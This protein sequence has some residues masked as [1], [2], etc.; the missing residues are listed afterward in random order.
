LVKSSPTFEQLLSKYVKKKA[1][2][3]DRQAK[4]PRS[5]IQEHQQVRPIGP[6]HQSERTEGHTVQLR[7]N[8]PAWTPPPP[9]LSMPYQYAYVPPPYAPNQIWGMPPYPFGVPQYSTWGHPKYLH[10]IGWHLQSRPIER[11]SIWSPGTSPTRL[12]NYSIAKADQS[13]R[14]H[15]PTATKITTKRT[16][17]K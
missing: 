15:I 7:P 6:P 17:P 16:S 13:G 4:R 5:P 3:S 12:P 11:H 1:A 14:G 8:I 2:P 10:S 9:Y